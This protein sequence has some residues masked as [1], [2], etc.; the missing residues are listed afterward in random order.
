MIAYV[1]PYL[2]SATA[3]DQTKY[4]TQLAAQAERIAQNRTVAGLHFPVDSHAGQILAR[5]LA[6]YFLH[7]CGLANPVMQRT[8]NP[9]PTVTDADFVPA[10]HLKDSNPT[11]A[12][13][14]AIDPTKTVLGWLANQTK[15]EWA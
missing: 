5:V 7:Y 10:Q 9:N 2:I 6:D 11:A 12:T 4:G 3:A 14:P 13:L 15:T 1:L 8:I